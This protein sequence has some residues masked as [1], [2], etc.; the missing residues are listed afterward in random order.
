MSYEVISENTITVQR[1]IAEIR[2]QFG[3]VVSIEQQAVS[4]NPGDVISDD[5]VSGYIKKKLEDGDPAYTSI[6]KK[7]DKEPGPTPLVEPLENYDKLNVY[8]IVSKLRTLTTEHVS[9][10]K[11][12]ELEHE[13][14]PEVL[15]YSIGSKEAPHERVDGSLTPDPVESTKGKDPLTDLSQDPVFLENGA[16]VELEEVPEPKRETPE[17]SEPVEELVPTASEDQPA[18]TASG[19]KTVKK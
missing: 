17:K 19:R 15:S 11:E 9:K 1:D 13:K 18:K 3:D 4:Y 12:Y 7:T 2:N 6:L 16:P 14:R 10:V 5:N 8:Q